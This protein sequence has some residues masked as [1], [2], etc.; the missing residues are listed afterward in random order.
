[1]EATHQIIRVSSP[2]GESA[3][4]SRRADRSISSEEDRGVKLRDG[5]TLRES[6]PRVCDANLC[7]SHSFTV[8]AVR[9][10]ET[11]VPNCSQAL[12]RPRQLPQ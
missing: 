8:T 4:E 11:G 1:M 7:P 9:V 12:D 2:G 5:R 3:D 10:L 6:R